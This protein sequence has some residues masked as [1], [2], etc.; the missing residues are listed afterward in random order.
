MDRRIPVGLPLALLLS[1]LAGAAAGLSLIA[2]AVAGHN[3]DTLGA[4][5]TLIGGCLLVAAFA[6]AW[7]VVP[8]GIYSFVRN[9]QL[10]ST[11]YVLAVGSGFSVLFLPLLASLG[12]RI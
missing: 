3:H 9:S 11:W 8:V 10:R 4:Y 2:V 5:S 7:V 1:P 12:S 6:L